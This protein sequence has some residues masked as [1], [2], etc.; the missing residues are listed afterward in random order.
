VRP[1]GKGVGESGL[2]FCRFRFR[3]EAAGERF[4]RGKRKQREFLFGIGEGL[5]P[6]V[7]DLNECAERRRR[8]GTR[9]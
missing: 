8:R 5:A 9:R 1:G 2:N 4:A 6:V 7:D 3:A